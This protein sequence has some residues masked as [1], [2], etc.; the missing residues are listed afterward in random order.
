M[1]RLR[2]SDCTAPGI[3][4]RKAGKGFTYVDSTGARVS[5]PEV[6]ERIRN[7]VIPP[8]WTDVWI[9]VDPRGHIQATGVDARGRRQYRYHDVWRERRDREKFDHML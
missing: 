4:R 6:L 7:L 1:A 3:R 8:A 9:C 5:D 2:R